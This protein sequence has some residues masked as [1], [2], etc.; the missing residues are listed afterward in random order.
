MQV[1][2]QSTSRSGGTLGAPTMI[3]LTDIRIPGALDD[4]P[5]TL[6]LPAALRAK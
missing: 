1:I 6:E 2:D 3:S 5:V 4:K